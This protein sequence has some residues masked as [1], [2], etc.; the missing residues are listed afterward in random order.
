MA[1]LVDLTKC[2]GCESCSVA[3]K[4]WNKLPYGRKKSRPQKEKDLNDDNW[5]VIQE[6]HVEAE[7]GKAYTRFVKKQC[8]HCLEPSCAS[9]CFSKALR[10]DP[11]THAVVYV[12]ELCV[13]CRYC[14]IACP[15]EIPRYQ[16]DEPLPL[17]TKCEFCVS[18]LKDGDAP[19]CVSACPT[20]ALIYGD[21]ETLLSRAHEI[22][23]NDPRY[24][25]YVYGEKELGGTQWL[26]LS[27]QPFEKLGFKMGLEELPPSPYTH[28][29]L[30][31]VPF[32][33]A[34]WGLFLAGLSLYHH[35]REKNAKQPPEKKE[36]GDGRI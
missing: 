14:M 36:E 9:A 19:A 8:L 15:C 20:G 11:D 4:L 22:I 5:T 26:Y 3:C 25:D 18:R 12:P 31:K 23:A 27:D 30:S 13:G 10:V 29:Y 16:W 33:A 32:L 6:K 7:N 24:V 17:V 35:R 21:R 34:A 28:A 2:I 1:V